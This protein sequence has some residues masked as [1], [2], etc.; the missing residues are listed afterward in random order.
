MPNVQVAETNVEEIVAMVSNLHIGMFT[1]LNMAAAVKSFDWW[2]DSGATVHVCNDKNQFKH[3]EDAAEG[4]VAWDSKKQTCSTHSTMEAEFVAL[5]A[6]SKEAEWLRNMLLD[7][8][9]WPQPMPAIS[10]L[11]LEPLINYI[12][13]KI[14]T[15]T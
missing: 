6:A 10:L 8:T 3:Y 1:E 15:L 7:I 4:A 14:D 9:L 5:A 11:C 13:E 12:K 2:Y